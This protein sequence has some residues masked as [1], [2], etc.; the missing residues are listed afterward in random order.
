MAQREDI[1]PIPG[2]KRIE[3]IDENIGAASITLTD[4]DLA[5]ITAAAHGLG[6]TLSRVGDAGIDGGTSP[7]AATATLCTVDA[8]FE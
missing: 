4:A 3:R 6:G 8:A 5:E 1:V 2:T 7:A